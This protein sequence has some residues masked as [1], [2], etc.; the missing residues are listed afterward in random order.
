MK[1]CHLKHCVKGSIERDFSDL[2]HEYFSLKDELNLNEV[3]KLYW[4]S[5]TLPI[6]AEIIVL[7]A[8]LEL[9]KK[10]WYKSSKSKAKA[11]IYRT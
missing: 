5:K 3:L 2:I 4:L 9:L 7:A 10:S 6:D 11:F 8:S 1:R